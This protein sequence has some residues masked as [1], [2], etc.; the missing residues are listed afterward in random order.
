MSAPV[1]VFAR[2]GVL[3]GEAQAR[4]HAARAVTPYGLDAADVHRC[5]HRNPGVSSEPQ[6]TC[7]RSASPRETRHPS[8]A[9]QVVSLPREFSPGIDKLGVLR[10]ILVRRS[11]VGEVTMSAMCYQC[12]T[13]NSTQVPIQGIGVC[14]SCNCL[15]CPNHGGLP[16]NQPRFICSRCLPGVLTRSAGGGPG[17]RGPGGGGGLPHQPDEPTGPGGAAATLAFTSSLDFESQMPRLAQASSEYR[18]HV[19]LE[20]VREAVRRVFGLMNDTEDARQVFIE[21][22]AAGVTEPLRDDV[23]RQIRQR[24][25]ASRYWDEHGG[26]DEAVRRERAAIVG[27]F[28]MWLDTEL[29][30]WLQTIYPVL[31]PQVWVGDR[32]E[33]GGVVDVLLLAD[34]LGV[35]AYSWNM[36]ADESPFRRLDVVA[37]ADPAMVVLAETYSQSIGV[38]T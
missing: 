23:A 28:E 20:S 10:V 14:K 6:R 12:V 24:D 31:N 32:D 19:D 18:A 3:G 30:A 27:R 38:Y 26:I 5:C 22:I 13:S 8:A 2:I 36:P 11:P 25:N 9:V 4:N 29:R 17:G 33:P 37:G 7:C 15:S 16:R 21:R 1:A 34:S 35:N